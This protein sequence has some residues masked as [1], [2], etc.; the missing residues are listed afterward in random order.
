MIII[1]N[2]A[3]ATRIV[4]VGRHAVVESLLSLVLLRRNEVHV[5]VLSCQREGQR[6]QEEQGHHQS[7]HL[8]FSYDLMIHDAKLA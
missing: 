2:G 4:G 1:V 8:H 5:I 3:R 6:S 7:F